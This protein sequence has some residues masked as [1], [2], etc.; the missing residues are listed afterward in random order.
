MSRDFMYGLLVGYVL[1]DILFPRLREYLKKR[2][3]LP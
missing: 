2:G 3:V 1:Y